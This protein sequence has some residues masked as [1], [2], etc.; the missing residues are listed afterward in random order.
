MS[1]VKQKIATGYNN[2]NTL[3]WRENNLYVAKAVEVEIASQGKTAKEAVDN[4]KE[5]L[6]LYFEDEKYLKTKINPLD[7]LQLVK[8]SPHFDY[9]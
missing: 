3:V 5:A 8:I 6:E 1:K 7:G 9:V 2:L 4:L